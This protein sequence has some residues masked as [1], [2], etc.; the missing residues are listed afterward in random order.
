MFKLILSNWR[1]TVAFLAFLVILILSLLL[2]GTRDVSE[3]GTLS[4]IASVAVTYIGGIAKFI[5]VLA[6]AWFGLAVTFPEA[7]R[8][9]VGNGFDIF[10]THLTN[11]Q[12]GIIALTTVAVLAIV[13]A[14]CMASS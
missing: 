1:E 7:N 5:T 2:L 11:S 4:T 8:F 6:L 10:W 14:L 12:K 13:A 9:V 3:S